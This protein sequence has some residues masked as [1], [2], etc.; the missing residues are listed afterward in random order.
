MKRLPLA[1]IF[2]LFLIPSNSS[3]SGLMTRTA[4]EDY[5][6]SHGLDCKCG[7]VAYSAP[8]ENVDYS[9]IKN[10]VTGFAYTLELDVTGD[11]YHSSYSFSIYFKKDSGVLSVNG[12]EFKKYETDDYIEYRL[13]IVNPS[14]ITKV[15]ELTVTT[16][17]GNLTATY[18]LAKY[19]AESE[20]DNVFAKAL[21][22]I[23]KSATTEQSSKN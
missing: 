18:S 3:A 23:S 10:L 8:E 2:A 17:T 20:T 7:E 4:G 22:E 5:L 21:Y 16:D 15:I 14:D 6:N 9:S 1:I 12:D 19:I 11:K 13:N